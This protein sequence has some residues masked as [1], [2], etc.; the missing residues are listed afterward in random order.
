MKKLILGSLV[1]LAALLVFGLWPFGAGTWEIE[2]DKELIASKKSYLASIE[3]D[4]ARLPNI[5]IILADDLGKT[6]ISLY[7][8]PPITTPNI[9]AHRLAG[10]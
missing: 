1:A 7:G 10:A 3:K 4:T 6:D 8:E 5:V 9:D 2:F